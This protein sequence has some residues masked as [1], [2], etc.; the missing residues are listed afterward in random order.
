LSYSLGRGGKPF[1]FGIGRLDAIVEVEHVQQR[2]LEHQLLAGEIRLGEL[3]RD[4]GRFAEEDF[5]EGAE[6]IA[7]LT[8][9]MVAGDDYV[10]ES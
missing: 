2:L 1:H 9:A 5:V 3:R 6:Q 8:A 7:G 10:G 4:L